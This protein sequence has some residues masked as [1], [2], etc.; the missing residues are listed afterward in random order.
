M[1]ISIFGRDCSCFWQ[2]RLGASE[3]VDFPGHRTYG[4]LME[5]GKS[6]MELMANFNV[7]MTKDSKK[8]FG[9]Q[10]FTNGF[11]SLPT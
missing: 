8:D 4:T 6:E 5:E 10:S 7:K 1:Q 3:N 9:H 11:F 2:S